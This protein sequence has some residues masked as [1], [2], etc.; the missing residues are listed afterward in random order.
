MRKEVCPLHWF[1]GLFVTGWCFLNIPL[2]A[3]LV[4]AMTG[5]GSW[6]GF[7]N[8]SKWREWAQLRSAL[9]CAREQAEAEGR[10][11]YRHIQ[12][13]CSFARYNSTEAEVWIRWAV[14]HCLRLSGIAVCKSSGWRKRKERSCSQD[15]VISSLIKR[16]AKRSELLGTIYSAVNK[17]S[18]VT[19]YL[20]F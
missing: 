20:Y 5:Q 6:V 10:R 3:R 4:T 11:A 7:A 8:R 19:C 13:S 2:S 15:R 12:A 9:S 16:I 18:V 1:R 17:Y 14:L